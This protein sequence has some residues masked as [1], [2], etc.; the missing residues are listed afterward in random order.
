MNSSIV[1][2]FPANIYRETAL[3]LLSESMQLITA[4]SSIAAHKL[5]G[6][7]FLRTTV[8]SANRFVERLG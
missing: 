7:L 8:V 3:A 1:N 6:F 5:S 4:T 2:I